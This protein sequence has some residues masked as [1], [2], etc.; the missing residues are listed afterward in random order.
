MECSSGESASGY[1]DT[2]VAASMM[3]QAPEVGRKIYLRRL[4]GRGKGRDGNSIKQLLRHQ[5]MMVV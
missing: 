3:W 1:V 2:D 5:A 4:R